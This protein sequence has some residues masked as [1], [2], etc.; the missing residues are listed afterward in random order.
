VGALAAS[1]SCSRPA[2]RSPATSS[3][4]RD[5]L[6]QG[7]TSRSGARA[8]ART[9]LHRASRA[10]GACAGAARRSRPTRTERFASRAWPTTARRAGVIERRRSAP[11]TF[12]FERRQQ[13]RVERG[14]KV[15]GVVWRSDGSPALARRSSPIH[16]G[17]ARTAT[18]ASDGVPRR[19]LPA[20]DDAMVRAA[21]ARRPRRRARLVP[22]RGRHSA[23]RAG[24]WQAAWSMPLAKRGCRSAPRR[25][26]AALDD[27]SFR[28]RR[29]E[30]SFGPPHLMDAA[31]GF[32]FADL[33]DG[34]FR[35]R[36]RIRSTR[37]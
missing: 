15:G 17:K 11:A 36:P 7:R 4:A 21:A 27:V 1:R 24:R 26:R 10:S 8:A 6:W 23:A 19:G 22:P 3:T 12:A 32:R 14:V 29:R 5:S 9:S 20:A 37:A 18:T 31:G 25:P 28:S 2:R 13:R 35:S 34:R 16:R 33:Y 30:W